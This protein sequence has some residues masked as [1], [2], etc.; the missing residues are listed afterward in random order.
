MHNNKG[1]RNVAATTNTGYL[2]RT[3]KIWNNYLLE[4]LGLYCVCVI[5][6]IPTGRVN[7]GE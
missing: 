2:P 1:N 6:S 7:L 5:S 3:N 4:L